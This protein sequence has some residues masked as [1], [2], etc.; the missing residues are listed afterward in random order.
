MT[1]IA[2][3]HVHKASGDPPARGFVWQSV[4]F[5]LTGAALGLR[6]GCGAVRS[7]LCSTVPIGSK[8][9]SAPVWHRSAAGRLWSR[10]CCL[11]S[12]ASAGRHGHVEMLSCSC[13]AA[14]IISGVRRS[15]R[16]ETA[17]AGLDVVAGKAAESCCP[18]AGL[19]SGL[20]GF[21][22]ERQRRDRRLQQRWQIPL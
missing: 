22:L 1:L 19:A 21:L 12:P 18:P 8:P 10:G 3:V 7:P 2:R 17:V 6:D 13:T 4:I 11:V 14:G 5:G 9:A 16:R 20:S 15:R